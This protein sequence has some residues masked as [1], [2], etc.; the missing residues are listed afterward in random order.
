MFKAIRSVALDILS[1]VLAL[2]LSLLC[3]ALASVFPDKLFYAISVVGILFSLYIS[4]VLVN[5][6]R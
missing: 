2:V 1:Y 3:I 6:I 5:K 4:I